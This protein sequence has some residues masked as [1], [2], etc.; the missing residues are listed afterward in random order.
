METGITVKS[1][2]TCDNCV[3]VLSANERV[4]CVRL[5]LFKVLRFC[6]K[7]CAIEYMEKRSS[8]RFL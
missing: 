4:Y 5:S 8:L 1:I 6:N 7:N 3:K 2:D